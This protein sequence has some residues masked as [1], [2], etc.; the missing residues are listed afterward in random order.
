MTKAL[1]VIQDFLVYRKLSFLRLDGTT[2][3]DERWAALHPYR[4]SPL[5]I[6]C[7]LPSTSVRE[8]GP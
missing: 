3:T 1:D 2:K 7:C 8:A 6:A 5:Q 4:P